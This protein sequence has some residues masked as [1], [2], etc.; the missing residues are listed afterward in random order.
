MLA[1]SSPSS[2][3]VPGGNTRE[4]RRR[5]KELAT[6]PYIPMAQDKFPRPL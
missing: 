3:W 4:I 5:G 1:L 6:L 2:E